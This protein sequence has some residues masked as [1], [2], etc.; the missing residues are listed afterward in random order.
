MHV[1][2]LAKFMFW[3]NLCRY[4]EGDKNVPPGGNHTLSLC[5]TPVEPRHG[6]LSPPG[7]SLDAGTLSPPGASLD[8]FI[9]Y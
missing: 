7:A 8:A 4:V 9:Y 5:P 3:E 1:H 2:V 6:T